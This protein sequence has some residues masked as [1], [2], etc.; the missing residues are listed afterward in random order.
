M[1]I[2]R[3]II[4]RGDSPVMKWDTRVVR[5]RDR[6]SMERQVSNSHSPHVEE[7]NESK[8]GMLQQQGR[9]HERGRKL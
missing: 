5:V 6:K 2:V 8:G 1:T 3:E 9:K 7:Q 4:N